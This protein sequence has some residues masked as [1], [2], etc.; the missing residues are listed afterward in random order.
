MRAV[1]FTEFGGP[2]V[3]GVVERPDPQP[4]QGQIRVRVHAAAINPTDTGLR[5]GMRRPERLAAHQPPYIAGMDLAG[6]VDAVGPDVI[7]QIGDEVI[8][9]AV[10]AWPTGGAQAE[11]VV[12]PSESA[13]RIPDGIGMVEAATLPMNGLTARRALDLGA[14]APGEVLLVTGAAGTLGG[15]L[16]QLA[17]H[18]GLEVV[19]DAAE[20]DEAL[21]RAAG[22]HRIVPRGDNVA[23][24]VRERYP[25][26][27]DG[28]V[29]AA[30]M[31]APV[32]AAVKDGGVCMCVRDFEGDPERGIR[33][34]RV[35][36]GEIA[37]D[38][39]ALTELARLAAAGTLTLRVADT[40]T[41]EEI[42]EGHRRL[43]AGGV[44]GRLVI[45]F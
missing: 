26:G 16:I 7:W 36:V 35:S 13:T 5:S 1:G 3:M 33:I 25:D 8:A 29:D 28:V 4:G 17:V 6:V 39:D 44:R 22:P 24:H 18:E 23:H 11:L 9:I 45:R 10:P 34:Q 38:Q 2:E 43:E 12:V 30:V 42:A 27:V 21:V 40:L 37:K 20:A 32:L 15:Y 19:A 31:G 14:L 41:P